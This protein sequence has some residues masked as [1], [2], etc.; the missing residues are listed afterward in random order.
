MAIIA[1]NVQ[2]A[3][4]QA[5]GEV[6]DA[7]VDINGSLMEMLTTVYAYILMAAIREAIQNACDAAKRAGLT[8]A[9]GVQVQL[10]TPSNPMITVI[11]K[12][13]GMPHSFMK[14]TYLSMGSSTKV[15][16]NGAAGGLGIGRFAAYGYIHECYITTCHASDMMERTYFQF[17]GSNGKPQV[18]MASEVPGAVVGTRVSFPVKDTDIDEALRAVAWLK[19]IMHL[20]MGDSFSVDSADA[21]PPM[22]PPF[23]GT[24]LTLD[25]F[26]AGLAG[27]RIY[28]MKGACLKYG[29]EG[30]SDG[31]LVVLT[32][33]AQ[34]IG[35]LPF[36][37]QSPSGMESVFSTGM[38]VEIPMSFNIP[39]MPSREEIKYTDEVN[40]LLARI[41]VASAKAVVAKANE[42]FHSSDLMSKATLSNLIGEDAYEGWNWFSRGSHTDTILKE[43]LR[44]ITHG[45]A[46]SGLLAVPVTTEMHSKTLLIKS[47]SR[48]LTLKAAYPS[49]GFL[50]VSHPKNGSEHVLFSARKPLTIV[51]NDLPSG[52]ITRFRQWISSANVG[53]VVLFSSNT[54]NE[55]QV[56]ATALNAAFGGV[57]A[58]YHTSL[59]AAPARVIV[60]SSVVS[61]ALRGVT[62]TRYSLDDAKQLTSTMRFDT[63]CADEPVRVWLNKEGSQLAGFEDDCTLPKLLSSWSHSGG[64]HSVLARL[65]IDSLYLLTNRQLAELNKAQSSAQADGLWDLSDEEL[66]DLPDGQAALESMTALKSWVSLEDVLADVLASDEIQETLDGHRVHTVETCWEFTNLLE[67]L[68]KK[69]RLSL[70]GSPVDKALKP[71]IDLVSGDKTL[72]CPSK[73]DANLRAFIG[74]LVLISKNMKLDP[75]DP[76]ARTEMVMQLRKLETAGA[77]NYTQIYR[78]ICNKFP[79][80]QALGNLGRASEKSI[81]HV[82]HSLAAIYR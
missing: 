13:S 7:T 80:I 3:T 43:P 60:K 35:G 49:R 53:E 71:H 12:G 74:G 57:L 51:V 29:R 42:L 40:S 58:I 69:P 76:P 77:V 72:H 62:L 24:V 38:V 44:R 23:C 65:G 34:G 54:P 78:N 52:G 27:V 16:D 59:M 55:A 70:T 6:M 14:S 68:S 2:V 81:E 67:C 39:F 56:A 73:I 4:V 41:D 19:E 8:F 63:Y 64:L 18:Q 82:C 28:P 47:M 1:S 61:K 10:P 22:L 5:P 79:L 33:Q 45:K 48:G 20:T 9:D 30:L 37:V 75:S 15:G 31:S 21:L 25:E 66:L 26:D 36:H 46:W 50:A 32:N 17:Q 11:D